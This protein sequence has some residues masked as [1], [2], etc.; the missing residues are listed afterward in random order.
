MQAVPVAGLL[1]D[2]WRPSAARTIVVLTAAAGV[3]VV[4][5]TFLQAMAGRPF[6]G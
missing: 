1:A 5:A 4:V 2:R 6:L 3:V